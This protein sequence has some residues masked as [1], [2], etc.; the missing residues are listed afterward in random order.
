MGYNKE[1][2]E[3]HKEQM[4]KARDKYRNKN[5]E[6]IN[7]K[8]LAAYWALPEEERQR[9]ILKQREKR[10]KNPEINK[11]TY[12]IDANKRTLKKYLAKYEELEGKMFAL[13]MVDTWS[14]ADYKYSDELFLEMKKIKEKID[15]KNKQI[16]EL[17]EDKEKLNGKVQK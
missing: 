10:A 8:Q 5:K 3:T 11:I 2:Y 15:I 1:Y 14:S 13:K 12:R 17:I 9:R 6:E 16:A 4:K 7:K